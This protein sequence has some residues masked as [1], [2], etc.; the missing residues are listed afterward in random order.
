MSTLIAEML[1]SIGKNPSKIPIS[2]RS[3]DR[4]KYAAK[5][6]GL[7]MQAHRYHLSSKAAN[8]ASTLGFSVDDIGKVMS[9]SR[10]PHSKI[11]IEWNLADQFEPLGIQTAIDAPKR[12]GGLVQITK[13]QQLMFTSVMLHEELGPFVSPVSILFDPDKPLDKKE[14]ILAASRKFLATCLQP[15]IKLASD[16][17][18]RTVDGETPTLE[19]CHNIMDSCLV[20]GALV[21]NQIVDE[22]FAMVAHAS[23]VFTPEWSD[24]FFHPAAEAVLEGGRSK[25]ALMQLT[26]IFYERIVESSGFARFLI[27]AL[28]LMNTNEYVRTTTIKP[29]DKKPA[30]EVL[31]KRKS[32]VYEFVDLILPHKVV[33]R[34]VIESQTT[35]E[36]H[37]VRHRAQHE[38]IAHYAHSRKIG[39]DDCN[40]NYEVTGPNRWV[41]LNCGKKRWHRKEHKRGDPALGI[42]EHKNR[43]VLMENNHA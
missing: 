41:C 7:L 20:G 2:A 3:G 25:A 16:D 17:T 15:H 10:P 26:D 39:R 33:I 4:K 40:H 29:T 24:P 28:A 13:D 43:I 22:N 42:V 31:N 27:G 19:A 18:S 8:N 6:S 23:Y 9:L 37:E 34:E 35:D 14:E 1:E 11:W 38:V 21:G 5:L 12:V 36:E 30:P 32:P